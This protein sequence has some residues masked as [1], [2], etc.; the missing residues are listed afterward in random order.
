MKSR[1]IQRDEWE[2]CFRDF[3]RRHEGRL[4]TVWVMDP[5]FGAQVEARGLPFEGISADAKGSGPIVLQLGGAVGGNVE[6][7]VYEPS[8]IWLEVT[9]EG[10]DAALEILSE[11]GRKTIL[12]FR[13]K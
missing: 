13:E 8:Q 3:T 7:R 6:H 1:F 11:G 5:R 9:D 12:E 2:R 4:A 10:K